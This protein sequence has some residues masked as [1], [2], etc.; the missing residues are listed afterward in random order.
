MERVYTITP[1]RRIITNTSASR[2]ASY[3]NAN[4]EGTTVKDVAWYYPNALEKAKSIEGYIA[5]YKVSNLKVVVP[6][7]ED[8]NPKIIRRIKLLLSSGVSMHRNSQAMM[9]EK[10]MMGHTLIREVTES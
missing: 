2:L 3:Y 1:A 10:N 8:T 4:I 6:Q 7:K 9:Y 5:F